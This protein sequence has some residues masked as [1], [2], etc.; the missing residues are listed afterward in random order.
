MTERASDLAIDFLSIFEISSMA[1]IRTI[2][3]GNYYII[4]TP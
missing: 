2:L 3:V 1:K 4:L